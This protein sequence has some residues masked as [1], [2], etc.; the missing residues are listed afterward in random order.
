MTPPKTFK[1]G[2]TLYK[3]FHIYEDNLE[4]IAHLKNDYDALDDPDEL[5]TFILV[6]STFL[7][8]GDGP[9]KSSTP[10]IIRRYRYFA[11]DIS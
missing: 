2:N 5:Y 3:Y 9:T 8:S 10:R 4:L 6:Y 7:S 1:V 11:K